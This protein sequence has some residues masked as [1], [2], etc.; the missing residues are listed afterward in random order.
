MQK[1]IDLILYYT[2]YFYLFIKNGFKVKTVLFYPRKPSHKAVASKILRKLNYNISTNPV[3]K[4]NIAINWVDAT[5][6][7]KDDILETIGSSKKVLNSECLDIS[8]NH[9]GKVFEN[10]FG[11]PLLL[12]PFTHLGKCVKKNNLN[13]SKVDTEIVQCPVKEI[14][15]GYVYL[16]LID[17]QLDDNIV[18]DYRISIIGNSIPLLY[19]KKKPLKQRFLNDAVEITLHSPDEFLSKEELEKTLQLCKKIGLDYGELDILRDNNDGRIYIID[20]NNTPWGPP[21][22][23]TKHDNKKALEILSA[24]FEKEYLSK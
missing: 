19:L 3:R 16:K 10:I 15:D 23:L 9:T 20:A 13:A 4:F 11:Y 8:K 2:R 18:I 5:F 6:R 14:E 7:E 22:D 17:A 12:D 24:A 21:A 1:I